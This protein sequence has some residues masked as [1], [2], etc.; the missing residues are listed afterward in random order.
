M[1]LHLL[2]L[3]LGTITHSTSREIWIHKPVWREFVLSRWCSY[4]AA[5]WCFRSHHY[6]DSWR[7]IG[8][9][10]NIIVQ[11]GLSD[12]MISQF[13]PLKVGFVLALLVVTL[14]QMDNFASKASF[15]HSSVSVK[16]QW[17]SAC[18]W[19]A[20]IRALHYEPAERYLQELGCYS[21]KLLPLRLYWLQVKLTIVK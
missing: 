5:W 18:R 3:Q 15:S 17:A 8:L 12:S 6:M 14:T 9:N 4:L 13:L 2:S 7:R 1:E 10:I 21:W 20:I 11:A 16:V 19:D